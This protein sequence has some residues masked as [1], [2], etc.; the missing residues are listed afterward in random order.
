MKKPILYSLIFALL[1]VPFFAQDSGALVDALVRKGILTNQE[2]EDIRADLVKENNTVPAHAMA[3]GK[4]T[5]KLSIGMRMQQQYASL[6]TNLK[7][8]I[9][10]PV[11]ID[12]FFTRR[13]YLTL[14]AGIGGDW[15]AVM[16]YDLAGGS[17]DDAIVEYKPTPDL[18]FNF[19]LRKVNV[20]YEE[21]GSSGNLKSI[22]RSGITRYFVETNNGRRLGAA[23]YRIGAF[24][25]GKKDITKTFGVVYSAAITNPERDETFMGASGT[26]NNATNR[27]A[28]WGNVGL[29]GKLPENGNVIVGVGAGLLPDQGGPS[30]TNL[31]K[32]YDMKLYSTYFD[33]TY[34]RFG[35]LSEYL[36]ANIERG[37]SLT[38]DAKPSGWFVQPSF[39]ITDTIEA[40]VRYQ[41]LDTD[42]RGVN[43]GDVV[44]SAPVGATMNKFNEWY[45]GGNWYI[46]S[47]DLKFQIGFI[48]GKT[49][50]TPTNSMDEAKTTGLRSQLQLQF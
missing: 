29:T 8:S 31:G 50:N 4:S 48:S 39:M 41:Q 19:G 33:L 46:K 27:K 1:I 5:D 28:F 15:G 30:N 21:R 11:A 32:G 40:V 12:H 38:K 43:L 6:D 14:K 45:V 23:S 34:K 44:R 3:A 24:L 47:N 20:G 18:S 9:V 10:G 22:E 13:I 36:T 16:T 2:A 37:A 42:S 7:T 35:L 25:D 17:Y 49:Q 26:G